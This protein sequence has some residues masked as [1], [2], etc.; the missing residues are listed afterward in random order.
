MQRVSPRLTPRPTPPDTRLVTLGV[1]AITL[2]L[3]MVSI[4]YLNEFSRQ[5]TEANRNAV[6]LNEWEEQ[7]LTATPASNERD[8]LEGQLTEAQTG[9]ASASGLLP[10]T[11]VEV[12][13]FERISEAATRSGVSVTS[14]EKVGDPVQDGTL[15][16]YDYLIS[17]QGSLDRLTD[18]TTRLEQEAFP[19]AFFT[20]DT[21]LTA[22]SDGSY[23][24]SGT[25]TI[26]ANTISTGT[27]DPQFPIGDVTGEQLRTQATDALSR[28][29]YELALS[30]LLQLAALEPDATDID[31]LLYQ[32]YI[33]YGN[34]LLSRGLPQ[35]AQEQCAAAQQLNPSGPEAAACL[36][37]AAQ[38]ITP[39]AGSGD[40]GGVVVVVTVTPQ[41][42]QDVP[43]TATVTP[44]VPTAMPTLEPTVAP[45]PT[46]TPPPP[47]NPP[48]P[49]VPPAPTAT[50]IPEQSATPV[51]PSSTP[52][53]TGTPPTSTPTVTGTPPTATP[54]GT[55]EATPTFPGGG[56]S[57]GY[58]FGPL[59]PVYLP[60]CALTQIKGK[61]RDA[62]TGAV[63]NGVTV[64]V[65]YDGQDDDKTYSLPSG[66]DP[67][68]GGGEWDVV[69]AGYPKAG[70]W[71]AQV[72]NPTTGVPLSA[73]VTLFTDVGP[74]GTGQSGH[75]VVIQDFF[76][77]DPT[78][79]GTI[80]PTATASPQASVSP[81]PSVTFTPSATGSATATA[82]VT[83]TPT[84]TPY[85]YSKD[86][87]PNLEI[88]DGPDGEANSTLQVPDDVD[89][90]EARV[91]LNIGHD[92]VSD[93]EINL[94]HPDG[95]VI[96]LHQQ[97]QD[98]GIKT[99]RKWFPIAEP[100][101]STIKGKSAQ[102]TWRLEIID[103]VE[104][105]TGELLSWELEIY[106]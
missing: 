102:G 81:T 71:Y 101:L 44:A 41:G 25:L 67:T 65:W 61:I 92:D 29:D 75:Q 58:P 22:N 15:V 6:L 80:V 66:T 39:T 69:L 12:A 76:R 100:V 7:L 11:N 78:A 55:I 10:G 97:G 4:Y 46:R 51:T 27:L 103:R 42:G 48:A 57:D 72:V 74:C 14:L 56:G 1:A 99:I 43:P 26:Y 8:R 86:E 18:F 84:A 19:A 24:I 52:T 35:L 2:L 31:Q 9:F 91:F 13:V 28:R 95:T 73:R 5:R 68:K 23:T 49:T 98:P 83:A 88:P 94:I 32:A 50:N 38:L 47:T 64:R 70:Q 85:K 77:Y 37:T 62:S 16:G 79:P 40:N 60:N 36:V 106:P 59:S 54:G 90:R 21:S 17:A 34:D 45:P 93:L 20:G 82:T 30:L 87:N 3:L 104:N 96:N 33:A 63:L 105:L 89:I 53:V